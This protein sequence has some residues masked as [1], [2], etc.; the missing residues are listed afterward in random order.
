[1]NQVYMVS[2]APTDK[3]TIEGSPDIY[4]R[5]RGNMFNA[6]GDLCNVINLNYATLCYVS[7]RTNLTKQ[8][9]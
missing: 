9:A 3:F 5:L 1:M 4:M 7:Y 2:I 8:G 6:T